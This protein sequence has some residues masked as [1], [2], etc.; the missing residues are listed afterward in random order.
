MTW[1]GAVERKVLVRAGRQTTG[2]LRASLQRAVISVDPAA[3]ERRRTQAEK[4]A[5][6]ELSGE[7]S[8]TAALAGHFLPAAQASAA[9][10][11][12]SAMAE[13]MK[14]HG[15]GGGIDLLRA[16]VFI[17]LLL[18]TLPQP[19]GQAAGNPGPRGTSPD[20]KGPLRDD[21]RS[22]PPRDGRGPAPGNAAKPAAGDGD[23]DFNPADSGSAPTPGRKG[24]SQ[25]RGPGP[26]DG[27]A[28]VGRGGCAG[29]PGR[30]SHRELVPEVPPAGDSR[31]ELPHPGPANGEDSTI[32]RPGSPDEQPWCWP[33]VPAPGEVPWPGGATG[34]RKT[35]RAE[36]TVSWRTLAG[37]WDE[38]GQLSRM[39]AITAGV[40]RELA[41]AAAADPTCAW[42]V[43]VTDA[44]GQVIGVTR[45]RWPDRRQPDPGSGNQIIRQSRVLSH[46]TQM[47]A[48]PALACPALA[49][50]ALACPAG[51]PEP[52]LNGPGVLGRITVTVPVMFLREPL[53]GNLSASSELSWF[54]FCAAGHAEGC[55]GS[56]PRGSGYAGRLSRGA[57]I[58]ALRVRTPTRSPDTGSQ[59]GCGT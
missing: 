27:G 50:P 22:T 30:D 35:G 41:R 32:G 59:T 55:R 31:D 21:G 43:V 34:K 52:G 17:G 3:A 20:G 6:V 46:R 2:Q 9:W 53:P 42:R 14:G 10:A 16:Q 8:G 33:P 15:A 56:G 39:G 45:M 49:W 13:V 44:G 25:R 51:A 26:Q 19:P 38:P 18:G 5:R 47:P 37:W 29:D 1:P 54:D 40:A 36:L 4:N 28:G 23:G 11:R 12:I 7:E 48:S 24:K 58:T 57:A